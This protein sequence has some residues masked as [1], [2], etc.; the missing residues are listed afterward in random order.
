MSDEKYSKK[1]RIF[2]MITMNTK[3]KKKKIKYE[4]LVLKIFQKLYLPVN[5]IDVHKNLQIIIAEIKNL[6]HDHWWSK[7][8][9]FPR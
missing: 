6:Q 1:L 8:L 9:N 2:I 7:S 4:A 5:P 3:K